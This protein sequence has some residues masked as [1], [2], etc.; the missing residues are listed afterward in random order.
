MSTPKS[1]TLHD[2]ARAAGVSYGT[3]S[4]VLNRHPHVAPDTRSRVLDTIDELGYR[5]NRAA[6][7][8]VTSRTNTV[9]IVSF[10]T[11][12]YGPSQMVANIERALR[13][14]GYALT[15]ASIDAVTVEELR[16]AVGELLHNQVDGIVM[17][18]PIRG[19]GAEA[20]DR[21]AG[22]TPFVMVDVELGSELPSI[23]ID[24]RAGAEC[25]VDHLVSLGHEHIAQLH[26][27]ADWVDA[28]ARGLGFRAALRRAGLRPAGTVEGDWSAASGHR[29]VHQLLS[30]PE[31]PTGLFVHNDQMALGA[32]HALREAG[33]RVPQDVSVVGYDDVPEASFYAPPLTTVRQDFAALGSESVDYLGRLLSDRKT[34]VHQRVLHPELRIRAS[35]APKE[36]T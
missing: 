33:L 23:V 5:P 1:V 16:R 18:T 30:G 25:A 24:Q 9:G 13:R 6:R 27:P 10:G 15:I 8:L 11:R 12:H 4:R 3:V 19:L 34:P 29:A 20:I 22:A 2:V 32:L 35:T 17:I 14:R 31:R 36:V 7:S 28:H 21:L 26:G